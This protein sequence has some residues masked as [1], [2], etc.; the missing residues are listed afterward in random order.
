MSKF[1]Q[2][3]IVQREVESVVNL[4]EKLYEILPQFSLLSKDEKSQAVDMLDELLEKQRVLY[5]RI[6]LSD[7]PDA[8][9]MKQQFEDQKIMLGIPRSTT[10]YQVFEKM[11]VVIDSYRENIDAG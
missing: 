3:E 10:P 6:S 4:Q 11:K 9:K 1:F 7:D 8:H 2:S 5:T